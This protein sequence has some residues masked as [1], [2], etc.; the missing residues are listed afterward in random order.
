MIKGSVLDLAKRRRSI[1]KFRAEPVPL[2]DI[3]YA[4]E[5]ALEAPSGANRQPWRF[6]LISDPGLK[7]MI[8]RIC[9]ASEKKLHS[10][11]GLPA[12]LENGLLREALLGRRSS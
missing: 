4:V 11:P 6:V 8:R 12:G 3:V 7:S 10:S 2:E 5:T 1:R 9:E